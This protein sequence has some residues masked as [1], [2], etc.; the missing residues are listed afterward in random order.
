MFVE[1]S[2]PETKAYPK[3]D[4]TAP[5]RSPIR[6]ARPVRHNSSTRSHRIRS[7]S[8]SRRQRPSHNGLVTLATGRRRSPAGVGDR[9]PETERHPVPETLR[10]DIRDL[11]IAIA[12]YDSPIIR[13]GYA[14]DAHATHRSRVEVEHSLTGRIPSPRAHTI[15]SDDLPSNAPPR[16]LEVNVIDHRP[17]ATYIPAYGHSLSNE[18]RGVARNRQQNPRRPNYPN[19]LPLTPGFPPAY[20]PN[21]ADASTRHSTRMFEIASLANQVRDLRVLPHQHGEVAELDRMLSDLNAMMSRNVGDLSRGYIAMENTCI[22]SIRQRLERL[23]SEAIRVL[24]PRLPRPMNSRAIHRRSPERQAETFDGLPSNDLNGLGDRER[25]LS[26]EA[27]SWETLVT[28]ISPDDQVPS[29]QSSF[30]SERTS[31]A[32]LSFE[33]PSSIYSRS[34]SIR[35][36]SISEPTPCPYLGQPSDEAAEDEYQ[37][38]RSSTAESVPRS[39]LSR[40]QRPHRSEPL[41]DD[42]AQQHLYLDRAT[43]SLGI[44]EREAELQRLESTLQQLERRLEHARRS[45]PERERDGDIANTRN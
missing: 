13:D 9:S 12:R 28:T 33:S 42:L 35:A 18:R 26:P 30:S 5:A 24:E 3:D 15:L 32:A 7:P 36:P 44:A 29:N 41:Q 37:A 1:P 14:P 43:R 25:S 45:E 6:R 2:E 8:T 31:S 38:W 39:S 11:E 21:I 10:L 27:V 23:R 34:T 16:P 22:S 4:P 40:S 17:R 20:T 19:S